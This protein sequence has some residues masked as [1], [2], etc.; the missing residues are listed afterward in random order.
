MNHTG[1]MKNSDMATEA[2]GSN[3]PFLKGEN[4]FNASLHI[5]NLPALIKKMKHSNTWSQ[6]ELSEMVLMKSP[7]K[8][9]V[10][11]ALYEGT[12][13]RSFQSGNSIT[14]QIMEGKLK[15]RTRKKSMT[16][17]KSHLLTF[18]EQVKYCLTARE[19]TVFLLFIANCITQP[20]EN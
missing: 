13:I 10:L 3:I 20:S 17:E 1:A 16:L 2:L 19:E 9:L 14:F 7:G 18:H 5:I 4:G 12:A 15:F 6:R 8:Q 11:T